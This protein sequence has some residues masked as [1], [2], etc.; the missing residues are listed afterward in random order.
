M[1]ET[2][3]VNQ[4]R[5]GPRSV[6]HQ[7]GERF[8]PPSTA[9]A[10]AGFLRVGA[11]R[12]VPDSGGRTLVRPA[13]RS[14]PPG[15]TTSVAASAETCLVPGRKTRVTQRVA[16][17][18]AVPRWVGGAGSIRWVGAFSSPESGVPM[19]AGSTLSRRSGREDA[20][21][22]SPTGSA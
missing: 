11:D 16:A 8:A 2:S 4:S 19:E 14:T 13:E 22:G 12:A 1:R 20:G 21:G 3:R 6:R 5:R 7:E 17:V 9:D 18:P 10:R 15:G